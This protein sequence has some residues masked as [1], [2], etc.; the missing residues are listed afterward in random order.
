MGGVRRPNSFWGSG[1]LSPR[2][3]SQ[4]PG[5]HFFVPCRTPERVS[6]NILTDLTEIKTG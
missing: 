2:T 3:G 4:P 5:L 6:R 1:T